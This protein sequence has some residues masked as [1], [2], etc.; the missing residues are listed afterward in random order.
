MTKAE[1]IVIKK[2]SGLGREIV[3]LQTENDCLKK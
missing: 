1:E 2:L 3:K